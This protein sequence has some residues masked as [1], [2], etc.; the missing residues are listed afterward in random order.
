MIQMIGPVEVMMVVDQGQHAHD[1]VV[2]RPVETATTCSS[3]FAGAGAA[4]C[5]VSGIS[6][7][8]V[9]PGGETRVRIGKSR[10][11]HPKLYM[12]SYAYVQLRSRQAVSEQTSLWRCY[13]MHCRGR[14]LKTT[15]GLFV[16]KQDHTCSISDNG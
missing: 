5:C 15:E 16:L 2:V 3:S 13:K 1:P 8:G 12:D 7:E 6:G 10:K 14:V 11:G 9:V 4:T